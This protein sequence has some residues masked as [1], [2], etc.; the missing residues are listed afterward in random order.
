MIASV[1]KLMSQSGQ[2]TDTDKNSDDYQTKLLREKEEIE[3][4]CILWTHEQASKTN[5]SDQREW[6]IL[7]I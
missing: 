1:T 5:L 4:N 2:D 6:P 7:I 3:E